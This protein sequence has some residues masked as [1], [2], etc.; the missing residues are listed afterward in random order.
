MLAILQW[1]CFIFCPYCGY[2]KTRV[3]ATVKGLET[4]RFR[5]CDSCGRTWTTIEIVKQNDEYLEKF[6]RARDEYR[7][8]GA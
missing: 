7:N 6:I 2:E 4:T 5:K 3:S 8:K 1:R